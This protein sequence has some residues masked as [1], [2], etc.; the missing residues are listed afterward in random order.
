MD[1]KLLVYKCLNGDQKAC[2]NLY[3]NYAPVMM[4]VCQR[5]CK[6]QVQAEDCLQDGFIKVFIHLE[7]WNASGDLGAWIRRIM[8]NT[9][10]SSLK[11]AK[12]EWLSF[13]DEIVTNVSVECD[14]VSRMSYQ[15]LEQLLLKMPIGYRTVFNLHIIEGYGY[16]EIASM[17]QITE[18][19]CRSQLH[20]SKNYLAKKITEIQ[21]E[22]KYAI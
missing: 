5:Y 16:D 11:N 8:V 15:E 19:T 17:L 21:A 18:S 12:A 1:N 6:S 4:A 20:K 3:D 9:C 13:E 14:A 22:I 7:S 2:K 10:L